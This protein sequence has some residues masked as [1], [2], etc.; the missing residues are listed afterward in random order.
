M[1]VPPAA[2]VMVPPVQ[3]LAMP[4]VA[5]TRRPAGSVSVKLTVW[6]GL[7]ASG[8]VIVN[9]NVVKPPTTNVFGLKDFVS[10]GTSGVTT[11]QL[12][13]TPFSRL[14]RLPIL[15]ERLVK[16]PGLPLQLGFTWSGTLVTLTEIVQTAFPAI[17]RFV[18]F[19]EVDPAAS[20][21]PLLSVIVNA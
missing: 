14:F 2:A 11:T 9:V 1:L 21:A 3:V 13:C 7:F 20:A 17:A 16:L 18:T 12:G 8:L 19:T 5:A 15:V 6:A 4:G 10:V